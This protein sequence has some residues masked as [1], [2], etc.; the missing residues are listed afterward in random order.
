MV[1]KSILSILY[2][3]GLV[4]NGNGYFYDFN[5]RYFYCFKAWSLFRLFLLALNYNNGGGGGGGL[6]GIILLSSWGY[7]G[8]GS[9]ISE[10]KYLL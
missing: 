8:I 6:E 2:I 10:L 7:G 9:S 5:S 1:E 4:K 3:A